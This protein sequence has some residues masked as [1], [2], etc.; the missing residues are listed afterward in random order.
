MEHADLAGGA[1]V[2]RR[3]VEDREHRVCALDARPVLREDPLRSHAGADGELVLV[4]DEDVETVRAKARC[5]FVDEPALVWREEW[6]R[7]VDPHQS[8]RRVPAS[9]AI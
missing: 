4:R 8:A 3:P 7:E 2:D 1:V 9:S 5:A 6:T